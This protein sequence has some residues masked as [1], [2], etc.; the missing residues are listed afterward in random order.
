M[1]GFVLCPECKE[2]LGKYKSFIDAYNL[3]IKI[4]DNTIINNINPEKLDISVNQLPTLGDLLDSLELF[5]I[6]CRTHIL[7]FTDFYKYKYRTEL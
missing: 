7:A 5:K 6:C 2:Y 1:S 3:S 4:I